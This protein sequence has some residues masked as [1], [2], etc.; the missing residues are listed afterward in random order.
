MILDF[1]GKLNIFIF[2]VGKQSTDSQVF[3]LCLKCNPVNL[4]IIYALR[5]SY[6]SLKSIG[7]IFMAR[8]DKIFI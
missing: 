1:L 2:S 4:K 5:F 3:N 8:G 6:F 7:L